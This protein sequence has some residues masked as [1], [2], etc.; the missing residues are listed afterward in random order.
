MVL[1]DHSSS[2]LTAS[3]SVWLSTSLGGTPAWAWL[4]LPL[5]AFVAWLGAKLVGSLTQ[6][7]AQQKEN[8]E[9]KKSRFRNLVAFARKPLL[10]FTGVALFHLGRKPLPLS[11][12]LQGFLHYLELA[13]G[14]L[15]IL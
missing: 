12:E 7:L 5:I 4:A 9:G 2:F 15:A 10:W 6:S 11:G 3:T 1:T 14:T 8:E 13:M